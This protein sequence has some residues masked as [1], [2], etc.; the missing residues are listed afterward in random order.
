M[1]R[2]YLK[3]CFLVILI[4][5]V[6]MLISLL[7]KIT[8]YAEY[9][10]LLNDVNC[11]QILNERP[12]I[13]T[14]FDNST[15]QNKPLEIG[16]ARFSI[17]KEWL[18]KITVIPESCIV[19]IESSKAEIV[20]FPPLQYGLS[21]ETEWLQWAKKQSEGNYAS[22]AKSIEM[23]DA[24]FM[25]PRN[26]EM[27]IRDRDKAA[28]E[29]EYEKLSRTQPYLIRK[30]ILCSHPI[31]FWGALCSS[32]KNLILDLYRLQWKCYY[33]RG[34]EL[35][36]FEVG[37]KE[38]QVC[39]CFS[40]LEQKEKTILTLYDKEK[41]IEQIVEFY[42]NNDKSDKDFIRDFICSYQYLLSI[43][44]YKKE[45]LFKEIEVSLQKSDIRE[46]VT[47]IENRKTNLDRKENLSEKEENTGF[48]EFPL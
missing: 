12:E 25:L 1:Q 40:G 7:S 23:R 44:F 33:F 32:R 13:I 35:S 29:I 48:V 24:V 17:N 5:F 4:C 27:A 31:S 28:C 26:G 45:E 19:V 18:K 47:Y 10:D 43:P 8:F 46:I 41:K 2:R 21:T 22:L 6:L 36:L 42:W 9:W 30:E 15:N 16:Y 38:G 39:S 20:L 14:Q 3:I 34:N 37:E 11:K